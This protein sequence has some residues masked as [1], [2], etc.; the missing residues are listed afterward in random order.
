MGRDIS[1]VSPAESACTVIRSGFRCVFEFNSTLTRCYRTVPENWRVL[2]RVPPRSAAGSLCNKGPNL[3]S[4]LD[5]ENMPQ[6]TVPYSIERCAP[7]SFERI[8]SADVYREP[9][10][11]AS[12]YADRG[13]L[14]LTPPLVDSLTPQPQLKAGARPCTCTALDCSIPPIPALQ[15]RC[16]DKLKFGLTI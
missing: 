2:V 6:S 1:T 4:I 8:F 13:L 5:F 12:H 11:P 9:D 10:K 15:P 3:T 16:R 14:R 7:L